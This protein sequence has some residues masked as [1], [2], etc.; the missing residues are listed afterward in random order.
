MQAC[1]GALCNPELT[2]KDETGVL[3]WTFLFDLSVIQ[4]VSAV[5]IDG[6]YSN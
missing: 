6:K 5:C 1:S 2:I 4:D 3:D